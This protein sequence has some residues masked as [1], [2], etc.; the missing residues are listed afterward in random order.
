MAEHENSIGESD[1]WYTPP[2]IFEALRLISIRRTLA[3]AL[4]TAA[5]RRSGSTRRKRMDWHSRGMGSCG[6]TCRSVGATVT[7]P[8]LRKFLAHGNG[9]AIVR[10]YT[11]SG[12]WHA[13]M[14][15]AEMILFP[16][17]KTKFIRPNGTIGMAPGH[18]VV[19]IAMGRVASKALIGS[20]LGMCWDRRGE[21]NRRA[22]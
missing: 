18:G 13:E 12:W 20:G 9:I 19:L 11:P 6:S 3:L 14:H 17:G 8:W 21:L 10:S 1:N 22:I 5:C 7:S 16:K 15:K 2:E 4:S